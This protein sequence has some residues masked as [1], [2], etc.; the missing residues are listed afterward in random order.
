[1]SYIDIL[2]TQL[3]I[4]EGKRN[5]MYPDSKNIPTIGI[6][7]NLRDNPISDRAV[8]VIFEDDVA[9]AEL[10]VRKLFPCFDQL[11]DM[12]KAV[13]LNM[14][15]NMG[16]N[17]LSLFVHTIAMIN[18]GEYDQAADGMMHSAWYQQVGQRA[19]RLVQAMREG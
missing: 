5:K 14:M 9:A 11:T 6:G 1:M 3:T 8:Q 7:H 12:R 13:V 19:V 17:T 16:Y 2:T 15:F 18:A 4:D 10:D